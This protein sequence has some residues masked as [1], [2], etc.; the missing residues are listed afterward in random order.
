MVN[1]VCVNVFMSCLDIVLGAIIFVLSAN[2][3]P[4]RG[5]REPHLMFTSTI[6]DKLLML[7]QSR[8]SY[9]RLFNKVLLETYLF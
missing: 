7:F 4:V 3:Y 2:A 8:L 5:K 1:A 6:T 9:N